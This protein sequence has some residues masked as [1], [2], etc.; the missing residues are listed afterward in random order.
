MGGY[1]STGKVL[2]LVGGVVLL[3]GALLLLMERVPWL[4]IGRLPGDFSFERNGVRF[5]FPLATSLL[6]SIIL[7]LVLWL[8]RRRG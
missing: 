1:G 5:Y 2:V 6:I 8:V 7:S 4:K 3:V